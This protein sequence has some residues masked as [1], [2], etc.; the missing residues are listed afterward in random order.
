MFGAFASID[1]L[2]QGMLE[3]LWKFGKIHEGRDGKETKEVLGPVLRLI[4]PNANM[5]CHVGRFASPIYGAGEFLWYL[6]PDADG[7]QICHYAPSYHRFLES[8]GKAYGGYGRRFASPI[9]QIRGIVEILRKKP[10]TRQAIISVWRPADLGHAYNGDRHDIPCTI[11]LQFLVRDGLLN[12]I[13]TM[14]SNDI[15]LGVPYDIFCFTTL[16]HLIAGQLGIPVGFY[17]HQPG[18]LHLYGY[19]YKKAEE[20]I[21]IG[22]SPTNF[23]FEEDEFFLDSIPEVRRIEREFRNLG[24]IN[25]AV[26]QLIRKKFGAGSRWGFLLALTVLQSKD[27]MDQESLE[28]ANMLI[29]EIPLTMAMNIR[30]KWV[31]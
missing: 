26:F 30:K 23:M 16:Q 5:L 22:A 1:E 13:A 28:A 29:P 4:N 7:D 9:G 12:C 14:R 3:Y 11:A 6:S 27:E 19:D 15:W 10:E 17:Q 20:A 24:I 31:K 25:P 8:D 2:W 21:Q 18:S